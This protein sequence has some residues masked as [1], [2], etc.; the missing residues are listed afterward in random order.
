M[1]KVV[2]SEPIPTSKDSMAFQL[3][4]LGRENHALVE[5]GVAMNTKL[6]NESSARFDHIQERLSG[7]L[8]FLDS[9]K[10]PLDVTTEAIMSPA[11]LTKIPEN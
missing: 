3:L 2:T 8:T 7:C 6:L 1:F 4:Q 10:S 11:L 9:P 5:Q